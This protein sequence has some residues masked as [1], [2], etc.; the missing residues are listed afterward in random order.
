[1]EKKNFFVNTKYENEYEKA[2]MAN[3]N[4][5]R[6]SCSLLATDVSNV[7]SSISSINLASSWDD[8]ATSMFNR[9][10]NNCLSRLDTILNSINSS[11][12]QSEE[13]YQN[14]YTQLDYLKTTDELYQL[15]YANMPQKKDY[16][17][18]V[19]D[20]ERT[21]TR[22]KSE[23]Y[24]DYQKWEKSIQGLESSCL[25]MQGQIDSYLSL[26]DSINGM[27]VSSGSN[28]NIPSLVIPKGENLLDFVD[29]A[30][31]VDSSLIGDDYR[32][33]IVVEYN[34][35]QYF[36]FAQSG[37][38]GSDELE[39]NRFAYTDGKGA[40][41]ISG[42]ACSMCSLLNGLSNMLGIEKVTAAFGLDTSKLNYK[43]GSLNSTLLIGINEKAKE[44]GTTTD[45]RVGIE[46]ICN[47]YFGDDVTVTPATYGTLGK[48]TFEKVHQGDAFLVVRLGQNST[49]KYKTGG[50]HYIVMIDYDETN[51]K[52]LFIDSAVQID[53]TD[54]TI[55]SLKNNTKTRTRIS[56]GSLESSSDGETPLVS[57]LRGNS[58]PDYDPEKNIDG[59]NLLVVSKK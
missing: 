15:T 19:T 20:G 35:Q 8:S 9:F 39:K 49:D 1:M 32:F 10:R 3:D 55:N 25:E 2:K 36:A 50:G 31:L 13:L 40:T 33:D 45:K 22:T 24:T 53:S 4:V 54:S 37:Y 48:E 57:V 7:S 12:K 59:Y 18:T 26:L 52:G 56:W 21:Y 30:K 17:E 51:D 46:K 29:F 41:T 23:Y 43:D 42:A 58:S 5:S 27:T 38:F 16:Q 14:L 34:G 44:L 11:F 47:A 6:A 28:I